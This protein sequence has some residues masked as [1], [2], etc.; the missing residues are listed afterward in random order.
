MIP[1]VVTLEEI[2]EYLCLTY[3]SYLPLPALV[4][5]K[6][7]VSCA[8]LRFGGV[9]HAINDNANQYYSLQS[10]TTLK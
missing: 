6:G 2:I 8:D 5:G 1:S 10:N 4:R 7:F 3:T 9:Q